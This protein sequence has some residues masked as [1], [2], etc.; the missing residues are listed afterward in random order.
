[1][2]KNWWNTLKTFINPG[3]TSSVPPLQVNATVLTDDEG[4]A[5]LLNDYFWD[6]TI[7]KITIM[8]KYLLLQIIIL[9]LASM[10]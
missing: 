5:N 10:I 7:I 6:Q 3:T 2:L 9:F 1:M 8:W 4:K